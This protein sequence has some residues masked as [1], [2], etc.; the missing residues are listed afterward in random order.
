MTQ[1]LALIIED[2]GDIAYIYDE[3]LRAANFITD[4]VMDG[5]V[6]LER[7]KTTVPDLIVLDMN[8][9]RV[10][11]HYLFKEIRADERLNNTP[12]IIATANSPMADAL[13]PLISDIDF[14]LIKP[15]SASQLRDL[16]SR[17]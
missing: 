11:G 6:A 14:I 13:R 16:A 9:P 2:N 4:I 15:V 12:I 3:G 17:L 7:L 5:K 8:L 1:R 10:S